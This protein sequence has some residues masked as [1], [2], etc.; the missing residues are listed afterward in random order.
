MSQTPTRPA[1]PLIIHSA[2][3]YLLPVLLAEPV[4]VFVRPFPRYHLIQQRVHVQAVRHLS[5]TST[6]TRTVRV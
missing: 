1:V 6:C 5:R 2:L 4:L 3:R